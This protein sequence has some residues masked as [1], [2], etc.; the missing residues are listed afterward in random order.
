MDA[1]YAKT[2]GTK[3]MHMNGAVV[4]PAAAGIILVIF[5]LV[6]RKVRQVSR[7]VLGT[8]DLA[9]GIQELRDSV[10]AEP[11]SLN[12]MTRLMLPLIEKDFP[13]FSWPETKAM[14]ENTVKAM[15]AATDAQDL[16]LLPKAG[17]RL[18]ETVRLAIADQK[19]S[20][21]R[22]HFENVDIHD[23]VISDYQKRDGLCVIR[24]QTGLGYTGYTTG[25]K[26]GE[27]NQ[28]P[29]HREA[30]YNSELVYVQDVSKVGPALQ[31]LGVN[32]PNC[33]APV[34]ILG[35]KCCAYCG[36]A[37]NEISL[38]VWSMETVKEDVVRD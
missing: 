7:A 35:Q 23:T 28:T 36:T 24:L 26:A 2:G 15:L 19:R 4:F 33:G 3:S 29:R 21:I 37:L 8:E 16:S 30:R 13:Q 20:G 12:G 32:C 5:F 27:K 10:T 18:R 22:E 25:E 9:R 11:L 38:R 31:A 34:R 14:A 1:L 17:E 6:R